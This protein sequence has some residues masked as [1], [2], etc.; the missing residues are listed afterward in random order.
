[1]PAK[2]AKLTT[3]PLFW[4]TEVSVAVRTS[5][6]SCRKAEKTRL[7]IADR[8]SSG[9]SLWHVGRGERALI[10][11][12]NQLDGDKTPRAADGEVY[13]SND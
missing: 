1:M 10:R 8:Q 13:D 12:S 2:I 3:R 9:E 11:Y 6:P 5:R 7:F 4:I